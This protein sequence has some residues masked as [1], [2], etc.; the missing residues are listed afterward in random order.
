MSFLPNLLYKVG[1]KIQKNK[2]EQ[3]LISKRL[4]VKS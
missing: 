3:N 2:K 1:C 4:Q